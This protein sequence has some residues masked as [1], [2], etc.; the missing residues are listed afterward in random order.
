MKPKPILILL[1]CICLFFSCKKDNS[2]NNIQYVSP[3]KLY[4]TKIN[5]ITDIQLFTNKHEVFSADSI[6][7]FLNIYNTSGFFNIN[8]TVDTS[9]SNNNTISFIAKDTAILQPGNVKFYI[10]RH[11]DQFLFYS[12]I[13]T[14]TIQAFVGLFKYSYPNTLEG[15]TYDGEPTYATKEVRVG[16][17]NYNEINMS[18]LRYEI[19]RVTFNSGGIPGSYSYSNSLYNEF[20]LDL[21]PTLTVNDNVAVQQYSITYKIR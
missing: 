7:N 6:Q 16:Y 12:V 18:Y 21:V 10:I 4:A 14:E 15:A 8:Q 20:N 5:K 1:A 9:E 19:S 17:G 13:Q 2:A 3:T 11:N